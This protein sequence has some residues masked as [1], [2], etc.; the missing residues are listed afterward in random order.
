[1]PSG[2][3]SGKDDTAGVD[4]AIG[5]KNGVKTPGI[6]SFLFGRCGRRREVQSGR[7]IGVQA[8]S[9]QSSSRFIGAETGE[10][11]DDVVP[12]FKPRRPLPNGESGP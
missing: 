11:E 5:L 2:K 4:G 6:E 12:R 1:M 7:A 3:P 10:G 8:T 9:V